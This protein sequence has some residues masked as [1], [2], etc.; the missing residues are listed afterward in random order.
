[1]FARQQFSQDLITSDAGQRPVALASWHDQLAAPVERF[2]LRP[3]RAP[4]P[5]AAGFRLGTQH[6]WQ[7]SLQARTEI[8]GMGVP[9]PGPLEVSQR[10]RLDLPCRHPDEQVTGR[11]S[12][13][14]CLREGLDP[15]PAVTRPHA[16]GRAWFAASG[17]DE[18]AFDAL[19]TTTLTSVGVSQLRRT[20]AAKPPSHPL[21]TASH[22]RH[23]HRPRR[24]H[25]RLVDQPVATSP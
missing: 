23:R 9:P 3:G 12:D 21:F 8:P 17:F 19:G 14:G 5:P 18:I 24:D 10:A 20:P 1:M 7:A 15:A 6:A 11:C 4:R 13:A 25:R 22:H 16:A 2:P